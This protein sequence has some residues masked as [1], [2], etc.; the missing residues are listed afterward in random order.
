MHR[1]LPPPAADRHPAGHGPGLAPGLAGGCGSPGLH[2]LTF[3]AAAIATGSGGGRRAAGLPDGAPQ[4]PSKGVDRRAGGSAGGD[5]PHGAGIALLL[6]FGR[7]GLL[8]RWL[9]PL[10]IF[11]TDNVRDRGPML[12]VSLS[13][14]MD[15]SREAFARSMARLRRAREWTAPPPGRSSGTSPCHRPGGGY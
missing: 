10:G 7:Q 8:G 12:F 14:L 1:P 2:R 9:A 5:P 3:S 13:F 15:A 6:V 4:L 11:F